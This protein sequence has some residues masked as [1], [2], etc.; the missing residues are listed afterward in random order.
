MNKI[1]I[2]I[3]LATISYEVIAQQFSMDAI[4][5][6]RVIFVEGDTAIGKIKYD[7]PK[8]V[9]HLYYGNSKEPLIFSAQRI[10]HFEIVDHLTN[11]Y[12]QFYALPFDLK[13]NNYEV[14]VIFE[15][16]A[17]GPM[18][19]LSREKIEYTS[20]SLGANRMYNVLQT[21]YSYYFLN[22]KG[23]IIPFYGKKNEIESIMQPYYSEIKKFIKANRLRFENRSDLSKIVSHYNKL[24]QQNS[25]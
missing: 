20:R 4:H 2:L 1:V 17:S 8:D 7:F 16:I 19:L 11:A 22:E 6:G 15:V 24:K 13:G 21:V 10:L 3:F 23:Q 14:P 18:T 5:Q 12:R 25:N 9:I